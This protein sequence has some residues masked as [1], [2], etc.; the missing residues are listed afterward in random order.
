M[1]RSICGNLGVRSV[2]VSNIAQPMRET[3][4]RLLT[5][6]CGPLRISAVSAVNLRFTAETAE[7]RRENSLDQI[8]T[9]IAV[10]SEAQGRR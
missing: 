8:G 3:P 2:F 10:R 9:S 5:F 6:L 4:Q 7:G 1:P